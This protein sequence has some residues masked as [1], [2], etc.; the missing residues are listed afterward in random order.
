M[1]RLTASHHKFHYRD[2]EVMP[3]GATEYIHFTRQDMKDVYVDAMRMDTGDTS[4]ERRVDYVGEDC[5]IL[6]WT[7]VR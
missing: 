5:I 7:Y 3:Y 4:L 2:G 1:S 6:K